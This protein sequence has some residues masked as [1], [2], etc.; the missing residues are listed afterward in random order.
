MD[1][2]KLLTLNKIEKKYNDKIILYNINLEIYEGDFIG[3]TGESG[4]GKSTLLNILGGLDFPTKG[5]IYFKDINIQN[6]K[7]KEIS[8]YRNENIGF[9]FQ[10]HFLL[11]EFN[12][13]ENVL[14][15]VLIKKGKIEDKDK[16]RAI[17]LLE[18]VGLK[19]KLKYKY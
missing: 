7:E 16:K 1:K 18:Y 17:E 9:I 11:P 14:I 8:K 12:V 15:N 6:L 2:K 19:E 13:I 10:F 4:S 3:I 5:D